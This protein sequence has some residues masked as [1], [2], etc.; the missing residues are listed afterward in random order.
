MSPLTAGV[1][2]SL[3]SYASTFTIVLTGLSAVG[4]TSAESASGL[5]AL[6]VVQ[7]V[8]SVVLSWRYRMPLAFSWSTPGAALLATSDATHT[9]SDAVGAFVVAGLAASLTGLIP[10]FGKLVGK[11]PLPVASGMLAGILL[12]LCLL[13]LTAVPQMPIAVVVVL[14]TWLILTALSPRWAVPGALAAAIM[15]LTLF[16]DQTVSTAAAATGAAFLWTTPTFHPSVI[17]GLGVPLFLVTMISQNLPGLSMLSSFG[18][19]NVPARTIFVASGLSSM[20]AAPFGGHAINLVAL[21]AA[22]TA[23][24]EAHPDQ[25]KRWTSSLSS[26]GAYAILGVTGSLIAPFLTGSGL[27]LLGAVAGLALLSALTSNLATAFTNPKTRLPAAASFL[28]VVSGIT[29]VHIGSAFWG[30]A[31]GVVLMAVTRVNRLLSARRSS[32]LHG[33]VTVSSHAARAAGVFMMASN[34]TGVKR[35]RAAW[36][37]RRW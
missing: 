28:V 36:R 22:I 9:F 18:Y 14:L 31:A 7:A 10:A 19:K 30:I 2:A 33:W 23:G 5:L 16:P 21:S 12:P 8:L 34:S 3:V 1:V 26:A 27:I 35:P 13:P 32:L 6:C 37:R 11:I 24:P 29:V 17:V 25:S 4:A 20:M 15:F